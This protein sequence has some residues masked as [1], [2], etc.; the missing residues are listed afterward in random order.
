M[1][2]ELR[3]YH[4]LPGRLPDLL[5]RFETVT[6]RLFEKHGIQQLG[7]WTV[8]IGESNADLV[9]ILK[10]D[11]LADRDARFGAFLRDPEWIEARRLSEANGPLLSSVSNSILTPTSFSAAR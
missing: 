4:C 6:I 1:I 7:F 8:A 3:V 5:R 11:S 9:Y 2:Y 10:W